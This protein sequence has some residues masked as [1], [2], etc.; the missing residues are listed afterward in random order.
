MRVCADECTFCG[1]AI[2]AGA[3]HCPE[4]GNPTDGIECPECGTI[5]FR[6]FCRKCGAALNSRALT[7]LE[8]VR[9]HPNF[10]R[11]LE[12]VAELAQ[13]QEDAPVQAES[14]NP[15]EAARQRLRRLASAAKT[16]TPAALRKTTP[17]RRVGTLDE[18]SRLYAEKRAELDALL[19][20]IV[21]PAELSPEEQR[22]YCSARMVAVE[23]TEIRRF[24]K[25]RC[26][27]C[28]Y[29]GMEHDCPSDCAEPWHGGT[30]VYDE[31]DVAVSK[32]SFEPL[33]D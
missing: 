21:P 6:S 20:S 31:E 30:W 23:R 19:D 8:R 18:A 26:W 9:Q 15:L 17:V 25:P 29:C 27:V 16:A 3:S 11:A 22:D 4:C 12:L 33:K 2:P 5:N 32:I 1:C 7:A 24:L 13:L 14:H 10:R 28:N